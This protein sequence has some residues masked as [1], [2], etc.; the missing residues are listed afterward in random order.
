MNIEL[1]LVQYIVRTTMIMDQPRFTHRGVMIDSAR[2]FLSVKLIYDVLDVMEMNK[3]NVLH[4]HMTDD[5]AFPYESIKFP[6]MR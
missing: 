3:M 1:S 4:W 2:H 5:T 6:N